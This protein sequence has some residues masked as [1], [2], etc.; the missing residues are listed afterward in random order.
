[1]ELRGSS[2]SRSASIRSTAACASSFLSCAGTELIVRREGARRPTSARKLRCRTAASR[3]P[4][5][6]GRRNMHLLRWP[7]GERRAR[8]PRTG[9]GRP[10]GPRGGT[11]TQLLAECRATCSRRMREG[12]RRRPAGRHR[13]PLPTASR[14]GTPARPL[15]SPVPGWSQGLQSRHSMQWRS[16][17]RHAGLGATRPGSPTRCGRSPPAAPGQSRASGLFPVRHRV[18]AL[19]SC[20]SVA[21]AELRLGCDSSE[22]CHRD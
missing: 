5:S 6:L 16:S 10:G 18:A 2:S 1:M 3:C 9:T 14:P 4:P 13:G 12:P 11:G 22:P 7:R 8:K 15:P 20:T 21:H 17:P 19:A